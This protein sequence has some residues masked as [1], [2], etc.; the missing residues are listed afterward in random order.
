MRETN[1]DYS[2]NNFAFQKACQKANSKPTP[3]QASKFRREMG[4]AY[5]I[6]VLHEKIH[7]P[8]D[9]RIHI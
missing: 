6:I 5:K 2:N 9:G 7:I 3:R 4:A 8:P 1:R